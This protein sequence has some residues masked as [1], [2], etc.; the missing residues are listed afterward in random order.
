VARPAESEAQP[1]KATYSHM[2]V[3]DPIRRQ[4]Q[5]SPDAEAVI[6]PNGRSVSYRELDRTIDYLAAGLRGLGLGPGA[7]VGVRIGRGRPYRDFCFRLALARLGIVSAPGSTPVGKLDLCLIEGAASDDPVV[8]FERA[9]RLWTARL[10]ASTAVPEVPSHPDG[11]AVCALFPTSGT[12]G[13]PRLVVASHDQIARRIATVTPLF[14]P[15]DTRMI[16]TIGAETAYGFA[17]RLSVLWKGGVVVMTTQPGQI[18]AF[19]ERHRVDRLVT[20]PFTLQRVLQ[21]L[22]P[23]AG[24]FPSLQQIEIGGGALPDR[25]YDIA[26]QRLCANIITRYGAAEIGGIAEAAISSLEG[27]PGA[28]GYVFPGVEVQA[29]DAD[30]QPLPPGTEGVLRVRSGGCAGAYFDAPAA[31]ALVFRDGWVYP[32]DLGTVAPDGL[33]TLAGRPSELINQGGVKVL[34]RLV[35]EVLL[36]VPEIGEAAAF[37]VPDDMGITRVWAAIVPIGRVDMGAVNALC[38][39]RLRL[40]AP[41]SILQLETLPR[42]EAGKVMRDVLRNR[43]MAESSKPGGPSATS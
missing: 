42:N 35:E 24:P 41:T 32:G 13:V 33:V 4:A 3:T 8:R 7:I 28:V 2:N 40:R 34:P 21:G 30:D 18:L 19:V 25:C 31:S 29:V 5:A 1:D 15:P 37:G 23:D 36:S 20:S 43:A 6:R 14:R 9:D 10:A 17:R 12:T 16:C 22:S 39:E 27:H 38:R 11:A 26:R